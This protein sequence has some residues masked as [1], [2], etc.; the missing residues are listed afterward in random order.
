M[1]Y[2][3]KNPDQYV[4]SCQTTLFDARSPDRQEV[5]DALRDVILDNRTHHEHGGGFTKNRR[6][7]LEDFAEP[8][9]RWHDAGRPIGTTQ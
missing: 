1:T 2:Q 6:E 7:Q 4:R 5:S 9:H 8:F 3:R